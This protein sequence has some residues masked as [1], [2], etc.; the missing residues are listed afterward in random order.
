M[1]LETMK[2][3]GQSLNRL[4]ETLDRIEATL[5]RMAPAPKIETKVQAP[6]EKK[7]KPKG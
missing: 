1:N 4:N 5:E 2:K 6:A 3:L 7:E